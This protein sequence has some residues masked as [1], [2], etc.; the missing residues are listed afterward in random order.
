MAKFVRDRKVYD[1]DTAEE[2]YEW[3][4][5]HDPD[6]FET[7]PKE[8]L[9][10]T[11]KGTLFLHDDEVEGIELMDVQEAGNWLDKRG[12]PIEAYETLDIKLREG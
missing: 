4:A 9:Y 1:T 12:A 3:Q 10:R 6:L 8:V 7:G 5:P 11:S 2:I